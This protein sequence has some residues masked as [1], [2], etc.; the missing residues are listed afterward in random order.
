MLEIITIFWKRALEFGSKKWLLGFC[1]PTTLILFLFPVS[2]FLILLIIKHKKANYKIVLIFIC[3]FCSFLLLAF[4]P[5]LFIKNQNINDFYN[6]KLTIKFDA[7]N[8]ITLIDN[9]F[10]NTKASPE[11]TI[12]YEL[13]QYLIKKT[14]ATEIKNITLLKPG[15]RTF[16]ATQ[17]LCKKLDV[18]NVTLPFFNKNL[19]KSAWREFFKLKE[20][21]QEKKINFIRTKINQIHHSKVVE[22]SYPT[23]S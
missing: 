20:L 6:K 13:K 3:L 10:F 23:N 21:L 11:K 9:G 12:D 8:K 18:K 2:F 4:L 16:K 5:K 14:G 15:Y 1:H 17:T 7:D 19:T 22:P